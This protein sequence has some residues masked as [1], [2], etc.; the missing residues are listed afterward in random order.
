MNKC[1]D[2]SH[3][4]STEAPGQTSTKP[5]VVNAKQVGSSDDLATVDLAKQDKAILTS[6]K[7]VQVVANDLDSS[8]FVLGYN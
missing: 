3:L 5:S 4:N 6:V 7:K 8:S 2:T 1:S